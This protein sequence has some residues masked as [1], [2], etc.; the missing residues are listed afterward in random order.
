MRPE[1]ANL[2]GVGI[3]LCAVA[4]I[5]AA[6]ARHGQAFLDKVFTPEEQA[7]C[8]GRGDPDASFAARWAAKEA[9]SKALGCGIGPELGLTSV[10]VV[11][12]PA[13]GAPGVRLDPLGE[14]TLRSRGGSRIV[15]SLTHDGGQ[16][17]A[18]A[19]VLA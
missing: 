10:E 9:V 4:R 1:A 11:T 3:D 14:R 7:E 6:R 12:D 17:A 13:T 18:Y 5:A 16:A 8:L 15:L 2:I 19:A